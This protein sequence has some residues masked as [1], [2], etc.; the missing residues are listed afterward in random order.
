VRSIDLGSLR[1]T[2]RLLA[3]DPPTAEK[4]AD[5]RAEVRAAFGAVA[6][7]MAQLGLAAGGTARALGRNFGTLTPKRL[8]L[9]IDQLAGLERA[10]M[11]KRFGVGPQRSA[12]LLGGALL[13]AEVQERLGVPLQIAVT[14]IREG[15]VLALLRESATAYG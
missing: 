7:P 14:G 8:A 12:T 15:C 9:A 1:L 4:V 10:K 2:E 5:A 13:F 6:P 11:A 3:G